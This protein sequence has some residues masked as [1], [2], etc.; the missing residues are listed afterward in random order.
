MPGEEQHPSGRFARAR[1]RALDINKKCDDLLPTVDKHVIDR[2]SDFGGSVRT[3]TITTQNW[4]AGSYIDYFLLDDVNFD[5]KT[6]VQDRGLPDAI[7]MAADQVVIDALNVDTHMKEFPYDAGQQLVNLFA[8]CKCTLD[9]AVDDNPP[10]AG[11]KLILPVAA[12]K[13]MY[14]DE[15]FM[16]SLYVQHQMNDIMDG[17][18]GKFLGF[19]TLFIPNRK[20]CGN[21]KFGLMYE[22]LEGGKRMYTCY[23]VCPGAVH[24]AEGYGGDRVLN[25]GGIMKVDDIPHKGCIFVYVPY[26]AG[27]KVVMSQRVVRFYMV[28][29]AV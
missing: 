21:K 19:D 9:G 3:V 10:I 27:A 11:R 20:L 13:A 7:A 23:A 25:N 1:V 24:S 28:T 16:S 18:A 14:N 26:Q 17:K 6:L 29:D 15:K 8:D 12:K 22:E 5:Y 4:E 2:L